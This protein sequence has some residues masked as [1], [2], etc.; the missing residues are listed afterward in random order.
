MFTTVRR[1]ATAAR[2]AAEAS[3]AWSG[4]AVLRWIVVIGRLG[5]ILGIMLYF[6][7]M[8]WRIRALGSIIRERAGERF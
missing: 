3:R 7:F 4:H 5:Q 6:S 2:F 1:F 8:W